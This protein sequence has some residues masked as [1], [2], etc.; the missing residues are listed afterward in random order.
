MHAPVRGYRAVHLETLVNTMR[1]LHR[2]RPLL[3]P[4]QF[5]GDMVGVERQQRRPCSS[6]LSWFKV[7]GPAQKRPSGGLPPIYD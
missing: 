3:S 2:K 1:E 4:R 6:L 5:D 7:V